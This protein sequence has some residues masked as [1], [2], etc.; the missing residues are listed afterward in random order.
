M[1]LSPVLLPQESVHVI[2]PRSLTV[3]RL[4]FAA[5]IKQADGT[6]KQ[7]LIEIQ[8][9]KF[10]TDIM[11]F[12]RYL[13][14]QYQNQAN[15]YLHVT[16]K[17]RERR[18]MPI[19][20]I[21]FLGY[22]LEHTKAPVIKVAR[23]YYDVTTGKELATTEKF[24]ESLTHD[25][26]VIQ[27]PYLQ[28]NSQS[29]VEELL[30]I[31]DQH[32]TTANDHIVNLPDDRYPEKYWRVIRRLQSIMVDEETRRN[33][34]AEDEIVEEL[35]ELEREIE[36]QQ[37]ALAEQQQALVQKDIALAEQ[38]EKLQAMQKMIEELQ[39]QSAASSL[40]PEEK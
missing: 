7:V 20:T 5:K 21:Y 33:M 18:A 31:F 8:K 11:R 2:K 13:G 39:Q 12:R 9:A 27:I 24:I 36:Q 15:I 23:H 16:K 25:S 17:K 29:E 10:A 3:Y 37:Q 40:P 35:A 34:Y 19:V 1:S 22:P 30:M 38:A 28:P 4:D 26:Y 14:Q 32:Q 6:T